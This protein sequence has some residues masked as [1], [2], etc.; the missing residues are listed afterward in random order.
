MTAHG[1]HQ[2]RADIRLPE[3][4]ACSSALSL[5]QDRGPEDPLHLG[6]WGLTL[7]SEG[8]EPHFRTPSMCRHVCRARMCPGLAHTHTRMCVQGQ[9]HHTSMSA[10]DTH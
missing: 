2:L 9:Q 1:S 6:Q 3:D 7:V 8:A 10:E 4:W 5:G